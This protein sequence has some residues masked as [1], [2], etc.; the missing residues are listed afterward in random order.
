MQNSR[1]SFTV[2]SFC[3]LSFRKRSNAGS[4]LIPWNLLQ[5]RCVGRGFS[6]YGAQVG[7]PFCFR[8]EEA[9]HKDGFSP[10]SASAG[11]TLKEPFHFW[12]QRSCPL[13]PSPGTP[14]VL[15]LFNWGGPVWGSFWVWTYGKSA[16][17]RTDYVIDPVRGEQ[18]RVVGCW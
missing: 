18:N 11:G 1:G 15:P 13:F 4:C 2:S 10:G 16:E 14:T 5:R 3:L 12:S 8:P 6:L 7:L 9:P 17:S